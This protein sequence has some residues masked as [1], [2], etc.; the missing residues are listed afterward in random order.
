[1]SLTALVRGDQRDLQL[2]QFLNLGCTL[3]KGYK[4]TADL[5]AENRTC[6]TFDLGQIV[7]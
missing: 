6:I 5:N 1:M 3:G 7:E 2:P 4:M